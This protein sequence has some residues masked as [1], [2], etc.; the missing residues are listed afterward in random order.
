MKIITQPSVH[1]VG[2]STVDETQLDNFLL[3]HGVGGWETDTE[4]GGEKHVETAGRVCYMSFAKPRP[5]GNEAYLKH[6]KEV[7][8]GSVLE[9]ATWQFLIT[10]VSRSFTHELV[11][12]RTG[13]SYSQLSQRYVDESVCEVVVPRELQEEVAAAQVYLVNRALTIPY[14]GGEVK[15]GDLPIATQIEVTMEKIRTFAWTHPGVKAMMGFVWLHAVAHSSNGYKELT[16]YLSEKITARKYE[17]FRTSLSQTNII[18]WTLEMWQSQMEAEHRTAIRKDARQA[19]RSVL[20]NATET[21]IYVTANARALRHFIEMRGSR[22]AEPEI[23]KVAHTIWKHLVG[24][25]FNLFGD[26]TW[27]VDSCGWPKDVC[28]PYRKV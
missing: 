22:F 11:R 12:H 2:R 25:A 15:L 8:H 7:G 20:P 16:K 19:A 21:K 28:T 18:P 13:W 10:G 4:C 1:L 24:E 14:Q 17:D 23:R 5:G 6:I 9:H 27:E 3:D 26:Y